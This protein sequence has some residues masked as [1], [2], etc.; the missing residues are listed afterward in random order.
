MFTA[1][2]TGQLASS[3]TVI[4]TSPPCHT[5]LP[6][7]KC[8]DARLS[9]RCFYPTS[10]TANDINKII[11]NAGSPLGPPAQVGGPFTRPA[12]LTGVTL[13][14]ATSSPISV[15]LDGSGPVATSTCPLTPLGLA[16]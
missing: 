13:G 10:K 1:F 14:G 15:P 3:L 7:D 9:C 4:C 2:V 16:A 12:A 6:S 5:V 11:G 8:P